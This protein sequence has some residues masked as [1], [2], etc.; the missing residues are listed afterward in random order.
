MRSNTERTLPKYRITNNYSTLNSNDD[1]NN[2]KNSKENYSTFLIRMLEDPNFNK[3]RFRNR[4]SSNNINLIKV[5]KLKKFLET[6]YNPKIKNND[7]KII[8]NKL[9]HKENLSYN[10]KKN[11]IINNDSYKKNNLSPIALKDN[12]NNTDNFKSFKIN[13]YN[14]KTNYNNYTTK[15]NKEEN[16]EKMNKSNKDKNKNLLSKLYGYNKKYIFSKSNILKKKNLIDLDKYQNNILKI[17][18]RKLSR[19]NLVR[20]YTELQTIRTEAEMVKPLPP[21]NYPALIIHSFKEVDNKTKHKPAISYDN[22]KPKE[23]DEYE[24]ELYIIKK[25]NGFKRV[26]IIKNKRLYKIL[27]ILPEHVVDVVFKNK[28]KII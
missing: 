20:L 19:D 8:K 14:Y 3:K 13:S 1:E 2:E 12:K 4:F 24:K 17:S 22:K 6:N 15:K 7:S 11:K 26:K 28:N 23:M 21:I 18:Q 25:S 16:K 27:E 9:F 5:K 10:N